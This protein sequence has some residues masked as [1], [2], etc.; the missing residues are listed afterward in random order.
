MKQE[1]TVWAKC[2]DFSVRPGGALNK[3]LKC[4]GENLI[5][6]SKYQTPIITLSH[7]K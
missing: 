4:R 6:N 7:N 2:S 5:K 1:Y 3:G